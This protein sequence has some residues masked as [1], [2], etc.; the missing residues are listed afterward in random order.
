MDKHCQLAEQ[1]VGSLIKDLMEEKERHRQERLAQKIGQIKEE[2]T[3]QLVADL[4]YSADGFIRNTAI[5]ILV[6]LEEKALAVL[7]EKLSDRDR[8]I[9]KFALDA[10]KHIRGNQS[11]EI[12]L[13]ALEDGDEN[14]VEAALEVIAHQRYKAAEVKL[15]GLLEKTRS[16][17]ILDELIRTFASIG[18]EASL[19]AI[20]GK[21]QSLDAKDIEKSLLVNTYVSALGSLGSSQDLEEILRKYGRDPRIDPANLVTALCKLTLKAEPPKLSE[22]T[23]KELEGIFQAHWDYGDFQQIPYIN[24]FVTL[25]LDFFLDKLEAIYQCHKNQEFFAETLYDLIQKLQ[26]FSEGFVTRMLKSE[27]PELALMGLKLI[28]EKQLQGYHPLV[29]QFCNSKDRNLSMMAIRIITNLEGYRNVGLLQGLTEWNEATDEACVEQIHLTE[30]QAMESL[31][32]KLEHPRQKVRKAAARKLLNQPQ[33]VDLKALEKIVRCHPGVEGMEALEVLF[34]RDPRVGWPYIT[35]RMDALE[36]GV[37]AALIDIVAWAEENPFYGFMATMVNDPS[38]RVRRR[39]IKVLSNKGDE[40][41]LSLLKIL[42]KNEDDAI[43]RMEIISNLHRFSPTHVL[44]MIEDAALS[45]DPFARIGAAHA[46][47]FFNDRKAGSV[48]Q[49][50]LEDQEEAL[51]EAAKEAMGM[52]EVVK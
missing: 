39:A 6:A 25:Q 3:A 14:V 44:E 40:Q 41:S 46:L 42:Y 16:V 18:A 38:P 30:G 15:L 37:R 27:E 48:L 33:D 20:E 32:E 7:K 52:K 17:W 24:A 28:Y 50:M 34:K 11:C 29:E 4:L 12:A 13:T 51:R 19:G 1:E 45:S 8:N 35:A 26:K 43:N 9:R 22:E 10:L 5:E 49:K 21:I 36:E 23:L 2:S 47:G 31:L